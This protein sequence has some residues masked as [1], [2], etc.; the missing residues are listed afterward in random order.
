M[1]FAAFSMAVCWWWAYRISKTA[2]RVLC[3][4][5][6][7]TSRAMLWFWT[8]FAAAAAAGDWAGFG[9]QS[10]TSLFESQLWALPASGPS[11]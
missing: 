2:D 5:G 7:T 11:C 6:T 4:K 3:V 10:L 8:A 1:A 9:P